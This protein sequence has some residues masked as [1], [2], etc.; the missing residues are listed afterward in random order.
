MQS[1]TETLAL[2]AVVISLFSMAIG[3]PSKVKVSIDDS[4]EKTV[5]READTNVNIRKTFSGLG[6]SYVLTEEKFI[7][8]V[9]RA[10]CQSLNGDLASNLSVNDF[11][12]VL[13]KNLHWEDMNMWVGARRYYVKDEWKWITGEPIPSNF[14]KWASGEPKKI[15]YSV[16]SRAWVYLK[17]ENEKWKME[18]GKS[19]IENADIVL[20][21]ESWWFNQPYHFKARAL[22]QI[23]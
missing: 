3:A 6:K 2:L 18:D 22:C 7:Y 1:K 19:K 8:D 4:E 16:W 15:F 10:T 9:A 20:A 17:M 5:I 12:N 21:T 13:A 11:D 14:E 23:H